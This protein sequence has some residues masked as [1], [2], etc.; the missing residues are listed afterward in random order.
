MNWKR[1]LLTAVL[2]CLIMISGIIPAMA[3][4]GVYL[5]I[6][7]GPNWIDDTQ[8]SG[9][10]GEMDTG[11]AAGL[12]G[13]YD[14]G[15]FRVEAQGTYRKNDIDK[16]NIFGNSTI[17]DGDIS[18]AALMLNAYFE[19]E[20]ST[21]ITPFIGAG[22]GFNRIKYKGYAKYGS[23]T[24]VTYNTSEN[25]FAWSL[26]AGLAWKISGKMT[27]DFLYQYLRSNDVD[28]AGTS[29]WGLTSKGQIDYEVQ[30]ILVGLRWY[31]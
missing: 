8:T 13:G 23:A 28:V 18:S 27:L 2:V 5:G 17:C 6:H 21:P 1:I 16:I 25:A 14:F 20:N 7:T 15:M 24:T 19:Y 12:T 4:E 9:T 10:T 11:Y 26:A 22:A 30:N 29:N 31:F 3:E